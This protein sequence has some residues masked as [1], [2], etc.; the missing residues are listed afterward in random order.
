MTN[1]DR[2]QKELRYTNNKCVVQNVLP[3]MTIVT[4]SLDA[5]TLVSTEGNRVLNNKLYT[6]GEVGNHFLLRPNVLSQ[7]SSWRGGSISSQ[8]LDGATIR[9][10]HHDPTS[11]ISITVADN[12]LDISVDWFTRSSSETFLS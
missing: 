12:R 7:G 1:I 6:T 3:F 9:S 11:P 2:L 5:L 8:L 4:N 10:I